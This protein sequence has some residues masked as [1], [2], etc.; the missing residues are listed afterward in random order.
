VI[1]DTFPLVDSTMVAVLDL[2]DR[3]HVV[4]NG[5]VPTIVGVGRLLD[6]LEQIGLPRSRQRLLLNQTHPRFAGRLRPADVS[7]RLGRPV[8]H[9]FPFHRKVLLAADLGV[10]V[11]V[12]TWRWSPFLRQLRRFREAIEA[13]GVAAPEID[14]S[15]PRALDDFS[16]TAEGARA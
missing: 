16:L 4:V 14:A 8:D 15:P 10:P 13:L 6:V 1:V 7:G 9:V 5:A 12:Q 3:V 11:A 2:S